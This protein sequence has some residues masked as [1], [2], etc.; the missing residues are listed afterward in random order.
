MD[1]LNSMGFD[2]FAWVILPA[3]I[4][5]ARVVDVTLGTIRIIFTSRGLQKYAPVLGFF[6]VLIWILVIGQLV[7]HLHSVTAYIC[8]AGGFAMGNY[9]GI[10]I[11]NRLAFGTSILRIILSEEGDRLASALHQAGFGVTRVD[12]KGATGPVL[13]I[14]TIAK[15]K[16]VAQAMDIIHA[17]APKA[18]VTIEE[19]RSSERGFFT[20]NKN[21]QNFITL[22]R[23]IK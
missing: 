1:T 22:G 15:R 18:F 3:I 14:Y 23:K 16:D 2:W 8:Y 10:L 5:V 21:P 7:Q 9:V 12:A 4:F 13:L 20:E 11:E 19:V 6:E 17:T